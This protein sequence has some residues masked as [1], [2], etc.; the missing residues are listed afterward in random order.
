MFVY[1][2]GD[3]WRLPWGQQ[4]RWLDFHQDGIFF[5]NSGA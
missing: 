1:H 5:I 4:R 3:S 2:D